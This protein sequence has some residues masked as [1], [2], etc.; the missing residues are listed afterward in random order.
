MAEEQL[1]AEGNALRA[2]I[3]SGRKAMH[4]TTLPEAAANI[5]PVE[6]CNVVASVV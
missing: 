2:T 6:V 3:E 4:D 5:S 1:I